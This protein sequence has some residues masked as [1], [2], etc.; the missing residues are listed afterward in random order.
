MALMTASAI[1][2][3]P[4]AAVEVV[5]GGWLSAVL[6][7]SAVAVAVAAV[8]SCR[9]YQPRRWWRVVCRAW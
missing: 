9:S 5:G 6:E 4:A 1:S 8:V 7:V 2:F 3:L